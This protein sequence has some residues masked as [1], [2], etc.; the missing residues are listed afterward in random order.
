MANPCTMF[1]NKSKNMTTLHLS[2]LVKFFV[3]GAL[4]TVATWFAVQGRTVIA[5]LVGVFPF[6]TLLTL[7]FTYIDTKSLNRIE[8]LSH[9]FGWMLLATSI[10]PLGVSWC[11]KHQLS[12]TLSILFPILIM[13]TIQYLLLVYFGHTK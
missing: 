3:A 1:H 6:I 12:L 2:F 4:V 7:L 11:L 10:F 13:L 5:A 9:H 8:T